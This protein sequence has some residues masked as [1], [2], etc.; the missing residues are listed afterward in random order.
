VGEH[1]RA[2]RGQI[3]NS[4]EAD[5]PRSLNTFRNDLLGFIAISGDTDDTEAVTEESMAGFVATWHFVCVFLDISIEILEYLP[6]KKEHR[7]G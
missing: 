6:Q 2:F 5:E 1:V 4:L 3:H 7:N